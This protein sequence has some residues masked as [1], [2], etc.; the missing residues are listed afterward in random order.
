MGLRWRRRRIDEKHFG[1]NCSTVEVI[2]I[3][4]TDGCSEGNWLGEL[5]SRGQMGN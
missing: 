3:M 2:A 1:R 5:E 4:T